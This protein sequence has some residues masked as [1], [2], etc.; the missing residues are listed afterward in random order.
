M[1]NFYQGSSGNKAKQSDVIKGAALALGGHSDHQA[2]LLWVTTW[3]H[4][5]PT[6]G[7]FPL[8]GHDVF[9]RL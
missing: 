3:P 1:G 9:R 4:I 7:S 6:L 5:S 2:L 8:L